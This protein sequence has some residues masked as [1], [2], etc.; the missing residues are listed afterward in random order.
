MSWFSKHNRDSLVTNHLL[1]RFSF[2]DHVPHS[3]TVLQHWAGGTSFFLQMVLISVLPGCSHHP[4]PVS[5]LQCCP[6]ATQQ[7][8]LWLGRCTAGRVGAHC[9]SQASCFRPLLLFSLLQNESSSLGVRVR[10]PW[11]D[12]CF[13]IQCGVGIAGPCSRASADALRMQW[14]HL[15]Q[16]KPIICKATERELCLPTQHCSMEPRGP[17]FSGQVS[18]PLS[19]HLLC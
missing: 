13:Q 6:K 15:T 2:R 5:F 10:R 12:T 1:E 3:G 8:G 19:T 9:I 14:K 18:T 17:A 7:A 16:W 4:F 11:I